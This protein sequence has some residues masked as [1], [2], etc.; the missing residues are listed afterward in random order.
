MASWQESTWNMAWSAAEDYFDHGIKK[1][2]GDK[3]RFKGMDREKAITKLAKEAV[4]KI[5]ELVKEGEFGDETIG[6]LDELDAG[7]I[8][9]FLFEEGEEPFGATRKGELEKTLDKWYDWNPKEVEAQMYKFGY[10]PNR[11]GDKQKFLKEVADFQTAHDRA[12]IVK[13]DIENAGFVPKLGFAA[14]P[15]LTEEATRQTLTGDYD[16]GKAYRALAADAVANAGMAVVPSAGVGRVGRFMANPIGSALTAGVSEG[17]RQA[18][19]PGEVHGGDVAL[20]ATVAGTIPAGVNYL[21]GLLSKGASTGA[22]TYARAFARGARG[23]DDPLTQER[24]ALKNLLKDAKNQ[25]ESA[26]KAAE[27]GSGNP[28]GLT[29]TVSELEKAEKWAE[30]EAKLNALGYNSAEQQRMLVNRFEH[31]ERALRKAEKAEREAILSKPKSRR[32]Q[33]VIDHEK[34]IQLKEQIRAEA[35]QEYNN[36]VGA[37]YDFDNRQTLNTALLNDEASVESVIGMDPSLYE[38]GPVR[39]SYPTD[40][41]GIE[42]ALKVYDTPPTFYGITEN[43]PQVTNTSVTAYGPM[44]DR[45]KAAFPEMYQEALMRGEGKK[46]AL[47]TMLYLGRGVGALGGRIEPVLGLGAGFGGGG[48]IDWKARRFKESDWFKNLPTEKKNMIEK[49]L[50]GE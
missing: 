48:G 3:N 24:N 27:I 42:N 46:N 4:P 18:I 1:F 7:A 9:K 13:N 36:A 21:Q 16:D 47:K 30:A 35:E 28:V 45:Y 50:K 12:D 19:K 33:D 20:A 34:D 31:A 44:R 41:K 8:R 15:A 10:D 22:K 17:A 43:I 5:R 29:A 32:K 38:G 23:A 14:F 2:P 11:Q 39:V 37:Y 26:E 49:L 40:N 6:K 25:S